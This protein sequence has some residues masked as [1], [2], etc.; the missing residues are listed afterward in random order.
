[1]TSIRTA[2]SGVSAED[3]ELFSYTP[4]SSPPSSPSKPSQPKPLTG[5]FDQCIILLT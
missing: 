5:L 2:P 1:M 3:C 4:L